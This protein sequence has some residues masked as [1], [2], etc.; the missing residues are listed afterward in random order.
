MTYRGLRERVTTMP[1]FSFDSL[2][3]EEQRIFRVDCRRWAKRFEDFS[4]E[5]YDPD[6]SAGPD[7]SPKR[8][9][10]VVHKPT[11]QGRRYNAGV[12]LH[13]LGLLE[14]DFQLGF[15]SRRWYPSGIILRDGPDFPP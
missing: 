2:P 6:P 5:I 15:Y 4:V 7:G 13:W 14:D 3:E 10:T 11:G 9:V 8:Q 1:T 12:G